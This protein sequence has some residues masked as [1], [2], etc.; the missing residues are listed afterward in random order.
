MKTETLPIRKFGNDLFADFYCTCN[1]KAY[2]GTPIYKLMK[3][4]ITLTGYNDSYFFDG[5]SKEDKPLVCQCGQSY[6]YKWNRDGVVLQ[7]LGK[8]KKVKA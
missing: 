6:L 8:L 2:L 3:T 1:N 5:V 7:R 4:K